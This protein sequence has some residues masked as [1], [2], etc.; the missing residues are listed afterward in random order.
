MSDKNVPLASAENGS[1]SRRFVLDAVAL[2]LALA[3][4]FGV[5]RY[6]TSKSGTM[7]ELSAAAASAGAA[8]AVSVLTGFLLW[9][10]TVQT[11]AAV[12]TLREQQ[13]LT[14]HQQQANTQELKLMRERLDADR[15]DSRA[16]RTEAMLTA[17]Q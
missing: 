10:A 9:R 4:G 3:S 12:E 7:G 5:Y 13:R 2:A 17:T 1:S 6:V 11:R 8:V 16:T 14:A 15:E